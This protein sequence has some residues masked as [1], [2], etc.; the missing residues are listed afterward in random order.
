MIL[1]FMNCFL[2][3]SCYAVNP[4]YY[5]SSAAGRRVFDIDIFNGNKNGGILEFNLITPLT[6]QT[7]T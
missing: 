6:Y 3:V 4:S 1:C 5:S 7:D 2:K